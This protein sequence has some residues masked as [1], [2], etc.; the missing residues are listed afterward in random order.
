MERDGEWMRGGEGE[1]AMV[2]GRRV[3]RERGEGGELITGGEEEWQE[4]T[5][6]NTLDANKLSCFQ[7]TSHGITSHHIASHH[8][9][10]HT[11]QHLISSHLIASILRAHCS[12]A[13]AHHITSTYGSSESNVGDA[14]MLLVESVDVVR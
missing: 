3:D 2:L 6:V 10:S 7:D 13:H 1:H 9:A 11:S 5:H 14:D 4:V 8:I 12:T